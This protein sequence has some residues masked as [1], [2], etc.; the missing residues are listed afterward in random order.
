MAQDIRCFF[1][2]AEDGIRDLTVTG[3]QTCALPISPERM[4]QI[5]RALVAG[6]TVE[7]VAQASRIDPWF[8]Y[9]MEDLLQAERWFVGLPE[10][11]A[12]ALRRMKR[13]GFSDRQLAGLRG[14]AEAALR[15][16]RW[17]L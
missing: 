15:A 16:R 2:Q 8:L 11:G 14:T 1:F 17:E 12:A 6:L 5:K 10:I 13:M 4:F 3:V 9:Q 7:E